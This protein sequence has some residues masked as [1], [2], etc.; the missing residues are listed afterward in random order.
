MVHIRAMVY[1]LAVVAFWTVIGNI[2]GITEIGLAF[3]LFIF[4]LIQMSKK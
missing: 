4:I 3:G 2:L 1:D